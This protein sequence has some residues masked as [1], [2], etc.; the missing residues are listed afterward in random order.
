MEVSIPSYDELQDFLEFDP[1]DP[2]FFDHMDADYS[3]DDPLASLPVALADVSPM[4]MEKAT[5]APVVTLPPP[6]PVQHLAAENIVLDSLPRCVR[7]DVVCQE[8]LF[9][10]EFTTPAFKKKYYRTDT[11]ILQCFPYCERFPDLREA[12]MLGYDHGSESKRGGMCAPSISLTLHVSPDV[13]PSNLSVRGRFLQVTPEPRSLPDGEGLFKVGDVLHEL[14]EKQCYRGQ[15]VLL[16]NGGRP[17]TD[18]QGWNAIAVSVCPGEAWTMQLEL[19]RHRRNAAESP[20]KVPLFLFEV[21]VMLQ[22]APDE[23]TVVSRAVSSLFEVASSR[24]LLREVL[25]YRALAKNPAPSRKKSKPLMSPQLGGSNHPKAM[26]LSR[27]PVQ[28]S[29]SRVMLPVALEY[30]PLR[31]YF[32]WVPRI[33]VF[34]GPRPH[35]SQDLQAEQQ[36]QYQQPQQLQMPQLVQM[37]MQQQQQQQHVMQ[38]QQQHVMQQQQQQQHVMQQHAMQQQQQQHAMQQQQQQHVMQQQQHVMQ[39]QQQ[40]M[41]QLQQQHMQQQQQMLPRGPVYH[42]GAPRE[43]F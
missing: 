7:R 39:H 35:L 2:D 43:G 20:T 10:S 40:Q 33:P 27:V 26:R 3:L 1:A 32:W 28:E 36:R 13:V 8:N 14:P 31:G 5:P 30:K 18:A 4:D 42:A 6:L 21:M 11:K 24:T 34:F 37:Q 25:A 38:Q 9:P 17:V 15:V 16:Q 23:F 41:R 12:R 19:T 29:Q 22:T